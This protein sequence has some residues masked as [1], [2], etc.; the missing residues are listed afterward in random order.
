MKESLIHPSFGILAPGKSVSTYS[1][2][3]NEYIKANKPLTLIYIPKNY[4]YDKVLVSNLKRFRSVEDAVKKIGNKPICTSNIAVG[5]EIDV[6][7]Y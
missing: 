1:D 4:R 5:L 6:V 3:I 2:T 7:D